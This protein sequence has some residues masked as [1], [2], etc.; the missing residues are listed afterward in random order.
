MKL[1]KD[2]PGKFLCLPTVR[3]LSDNLGL[4]NVKKKKKKKKKKRKAVS[5]L[6]PEYR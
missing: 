5:L 2:I 3:C 4:Y 6:V 1:P